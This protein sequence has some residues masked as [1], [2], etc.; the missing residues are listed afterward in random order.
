M[1]IK[2]SD[3]RIVIDE[4][5]N[6]PSGIKLIRVGGLSPVKQKPGTAPENRGVWAFIWP[7]A[8]PFLLGST[9][10]EGRAKPG[11]SRWD[12]LQREGWTRFVHS[13]RIYTHLPVTGAPLVKDWYMTDGE[14]LASYMTKNFAA[15]VRAVR[16]D[17]RKNGWNI[18]AKPIL[19]NPFRGYSKDEF[20]VFVPRPD[21]RGF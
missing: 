7:Y 18:P 13:G 20:E 8:E 15:T 5:V 19:A 10:P 21:E 1:L 16:Q 6:S 12:Q 14:T 3:L 17:Y 2:V 4:A 11:K 9:G